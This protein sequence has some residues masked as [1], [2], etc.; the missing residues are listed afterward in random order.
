[1]AGLQYEEWIVVYQST[2][3]YESD[4]VRDRLDD[5][6]IPAIVLTQRDHAFN[7]TLGEMA[8]VNVLVPPEYVERAREVLTSEP[9]TDEELEEAALQ[10]DPNAPPAHDP[11][12]EAMLD[13]GNER[14]RFRKKPA[15]D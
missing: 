1:M 7:L 5:A 8:S 3:D 13:S 15:D 14:I 10:A 6:G 4:I 2:T 12:E 11:D 9:L